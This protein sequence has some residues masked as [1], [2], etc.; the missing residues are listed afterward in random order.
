[1]INEILQWI[2]IA[3][4]ATP[5]ITRLVRDFKKAGEEDA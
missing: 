2:A 1:M 3:A 5:E 4:I